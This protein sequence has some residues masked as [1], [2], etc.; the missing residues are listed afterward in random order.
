MSCI[1]VW[2]CPLLCSLTHPASPFVAAVVAQAAPADQAPTGDAALTKLCRDDTSRYTFAFAADPDATFVPKEVFKWTNP[3]RDRQLGVVSMWIK[4]GRTEAITTVFTHPVSKEQL[5][6]YHEHQSLSPQRITATVKGGNRW[7]PAQPGVTLRPIPDAPEPADTPAARLRQ[8]RNLTRDFS[9]H[10][11]SYYSGEKR[12]EL[13][14]LSQP[15]YRYESTNPEVL[16]GAAF[17]FV[18]SAGTDPEL[19]LLIEARPEKSRWTWQYAAARFS[20]HSLFL[21]LRDQEVWTFINEGHI[22]SFAAGVNDT[23]Y[24]FRDRVASDPA[25]RGEAGK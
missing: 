15:L 5:N 9:A 19:I 21:N 10:S 23:Y 6:V 12:W 3:V 11:V 14:M 2:L 18:S 24:M 17:S 7:T 20:D 4:D 8:M 16:D 13:R 1:V 22:W 25:E